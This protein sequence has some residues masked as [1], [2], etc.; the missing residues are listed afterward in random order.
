MD[1]KFFAIFA[2]IIIA[3]LSVTMNL[4]NSDPSNHPVEDNV[5][6]IGHLPSDHDTALFVAKEKKMFEKE[7]LTV[8]LTQFSNGGDLITA[9]ASGDIDVGYAGNAPAMSSISQK[10][11][12]KI[13]SGAQLEG[14]SIIA[15]KKSKIN[16]VADLKGKNVATPGEATIQN[17]LLIYAL[18]QSGVSPNKVEFTTMKAAQMTDAL[19]AGKIDAMIIWEPYASI[20]VK[21]GAGKLVETSGEIMPKHP[22]CCVVARE[23]FIKHH[24][25]NLKK[26]LKAHKEATEFI[27]ENP[28]EAAKCLPDDVVPDPA[29]QKDVIANTTF[30]YGLDDN[31]RQ[32]V[33]NFMNVEVHFGIL[34]KP[35]TE[36]QLF[37][38]I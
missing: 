21:S 30:I 4:V 22:C 29:L 38:D 24:K 36:N 31:Y 3:F 16:T 32:E 27:S 6:R 37:A 7:G 13:V 35:L 17:I 12:I 23:D 5:V 2:I 8:E 28:S 34:D 10:V 20:A 26:V 1:K 11:P 14:S 25:D 15:S 9:M 18:N 33:M 19:R